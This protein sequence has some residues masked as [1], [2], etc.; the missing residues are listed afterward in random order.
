[1]QHRYPIALL[2]SLGLRVTSF[3][4]SPPWHWG[5]VPVVA[6]YWPFG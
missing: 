3:I 6:N 4:Q 2:S 1:V 5:A